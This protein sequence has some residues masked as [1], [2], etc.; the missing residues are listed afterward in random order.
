MSWNVIMTEKRNG[1]E[2][3]ISSHDSKVIAQSYLESYA[4]WDTRGIL[5]F[6]LEEVNG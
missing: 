6:R 4:E 2:R 3:V 5:R 1:E